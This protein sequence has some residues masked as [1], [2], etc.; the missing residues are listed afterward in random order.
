M[1]TS[2]LDTAAQ[3]ARNQH[4][5]PL[6]QDFACSDVDSF[7]QVQFG[8]A[9]QRDNW[10]SLLLEKV[11]E[12]PSI[13]SAVVVREVGLHWQVHR[14]ECGRV[15]RLRDRELVQITCVVDGRGEHMRDRIRRVQDVCLRR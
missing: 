6:E 7:T 11:V 13:L 14:E 1:E 12:H 2:G 5:L 4:S 10:H 3:I 9:I 8:A 15:G